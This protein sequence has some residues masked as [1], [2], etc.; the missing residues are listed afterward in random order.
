M[1]YFYT[2]GA[3]HQHIASLRE[4]REMRSLG[5]A[6]AATAAGGSGSST[7]ARGDGRRGFDFDIGTD[8]DYA[9][10][11]DARLAA[12]EYR[13]R[14]RYSSN[15]T[16]SNSNSN[17]SN[18]TSNRADT[19]AQFVFSGGSSSSRTARTDP[20]T[21]TS[22]NST[23]NSNSNSTNVGGFTFVNEFGRS[24][25]TAP[26]DRQMGTTISTARANRLGYSER[27]GDVSASG[28]STS[29][30]SRQQRASSRWTRSQ[31]SDAPK[32]VDNDDVNADGSSGMQLLSRTAV[33][34]GS[35]SGGSGSSSG[36]AAAA[37]AAA[38]SQP[39][40]TKGEHM[41]HGSLPLSCAGINAILLSLWYQLLTCRI[42]NTPT[43]QQ[44]SILAIIE[45]QH[46]QISIIAWQHYCF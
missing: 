30:T 37:A 25:R 36:A 10:W 19:A 34:S 8:F 22:S 27:V 28:S 31:A 43:A 33:A 3:A 1:L 26:A 44:R 42:V 40:S 14:V 12:E 16:N 32:A 9:D 39:P 17:S 7:S 24:S 6:A 15:S 21:A 2:T 35:S 41:L 5:R 23:S 46:S 11:R 20:T 38:A 13:P 18:S 45:H 4:M 29:G